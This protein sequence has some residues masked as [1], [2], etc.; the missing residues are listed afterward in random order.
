MAKLHSKTPSVERLAVHLPNMNLVIYR[1]KA[2]LSSLLSSN[3]CQRTTLTEWFVANQQYLVANELTY[4]DFPMKW[5]WD[6]SGR[7]WKPR[8][9]RYNQVGRMYNVH[10]SQERR[11]IY[12]GY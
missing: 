6:A 7:F 8:H 1:P 10:P 12:G 11:I 2:N 9:E 4:C 3:F 5:S